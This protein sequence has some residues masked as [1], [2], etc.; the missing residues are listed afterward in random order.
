MRVD[1]VAGNVRPAPPSTPL[2]QA[3]SVPTMMATAMPKSAVTS[4]IDLIRNGLDRTSS[5]CTP[6]SHHFPCHLNC[7]P[8]YRQY[9]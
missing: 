4:R 6:V 2:S 1:D 3:V 9:Q 8:F 7:Q 5:A